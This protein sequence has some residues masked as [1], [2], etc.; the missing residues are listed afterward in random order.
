M[1]RTEVI[2][3][4]EQDKEI[5]T[6]E[7][8]QAHHDGILHRAF[9]VF[10]FDR[11]GRML[12]QQRAAE[13]YH[14]GSLWTNA[15]CSHPQPG[16]ETLSSAKRRL[17]EELGF[18]TDIEKVFHFVY[19]A[20]FENGLIEHEFDHVFAGEYEGQIN[21][22]RDEVMDVAYRTVEQIH[23]ELRSDPQKYTPWFHLAFPKIE[24]WWTSRKRKPLH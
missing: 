9:S 18:E 24:S 1:E 13:K 17:R 10:V 19:R 20:E 23:D 6:C 11:E 22:N 7:K 5:G 12:L 15:C 8:M 14:S 3:V 4:D 21:F 16:E 2:L